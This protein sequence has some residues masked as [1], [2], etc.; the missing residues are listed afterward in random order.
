M[1]GRSGC[2]R[3]SCDAKDGGEYSPQQVHIEYIYIYSKTV[4]VI[5]TCHTAY[6][7]KLLMPKMETPQVYGLRTFIINYFSYLKVEASMYS[8]YSKHTEAKYND[9]QVL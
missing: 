6:P 3:M 8:I 1:V 7:M 9:I 4:A 5:H 2:G